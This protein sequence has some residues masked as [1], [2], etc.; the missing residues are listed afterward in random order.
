MDSVGTN[1]L[2]ASTVHQEMV[3][4]FRSQVVG[5]VPEMNNELSARFRNLAFMFRSPPAGRKPPT[6]VLSCEYVFRIT[7]V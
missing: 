6:S 5:N 1:R 7:P 3:L 4:P 2:F